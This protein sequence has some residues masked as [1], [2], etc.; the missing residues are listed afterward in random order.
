VCGAGAPSGL[1]ASD[2]FLKEI[3]PTIMATAAYRDHGLIVIAS[4]SPAS[5]TAGRR[6]GALL[7]SPFLASGATDTTSYDN[8]SLLRSLERLYGVLP[9]GHAEDKGVAPFGADVYRATK[10]AAKAASRHG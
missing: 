8:F 2:A 5:A 6:V 7:L 3:L 10:R 4:D 1:A 9:L